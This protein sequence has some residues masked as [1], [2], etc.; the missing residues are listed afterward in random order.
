LIFVILFMPEGLLGWFEK[1]KHAKKE[2]RP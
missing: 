1:K 2:N